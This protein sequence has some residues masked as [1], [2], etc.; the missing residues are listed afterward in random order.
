MS[1]L[2]GLN[3]RKKKYFSS[4]TLALSEV[5]LG[6]VFEKRIDAGDGGDDMGH[7]L[8]VTVRPE[9]KLLGAHGCCG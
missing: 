1:H 2:H 9:S 4:S 6:A 8:H 7:P 3:D 5:G